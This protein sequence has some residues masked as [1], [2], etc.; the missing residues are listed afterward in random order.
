MLAQIR[1][2]LKEYQQLLE[3][4]K[5]TPVRSLAILTPAPLDLKEVNFF[6]KNTVL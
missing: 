3:E 6:I 1:Q 5:R 4:D 2:E